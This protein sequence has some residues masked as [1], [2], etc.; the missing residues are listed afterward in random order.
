MILQIFLQDFLLK[1]IPIYF[2][3][4]NFFLVLSVMKLVNDQQR[5]KLKTFSGHCFFNF[6]WIYP[7]SYKMDQNKSFQ[8]K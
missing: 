4:P 5:N 8:M 1:V 2:F 7:F 6:Y 3:I